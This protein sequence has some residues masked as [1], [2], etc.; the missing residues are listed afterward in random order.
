MKISFPSMI[1]F[2]GLLCLLL[3]L[4]CASSPSSLRATNA[5][6]RGQ[7]YGSPDEALAALKGAFASGDPEQLVLIYGE[8]G[9]NIIITGDPT[10]DKVMLRKMSARLSQRAELLPVQSSEYSEEQWYKVRF[11][12]EGW[13]MRI[14]LINRDNGWYFET[15]YAEDAARDTR[16]AINEVETVATL[17][18]IMQAQ[19]EYILTDHDGDGVRA[20]AS[21]F[22]SSPGKHDGLYWPA[23]PGTQASPLEDVIAEALGDGY[24][25]AQGRNSSYEGYRYRILTA[26]GAKARGGKR[27]YLDNGALTKGYAVL[28]YPV[29]WNSSGLKS[30]LASADG[31]VFK[32]DMGNRTESLGASM[33]EFNPDPTW[34]L[35]EH[36]DN[37]S[38]RIVH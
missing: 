21:Y 31:K 9:R 13:L 33:K 23:A 12:I 11:G 34:A 10:A 5:Q 30:F 25:F 16:Q 1:K 22:I 38:T 8:V 27:S 28:A 35:V 15:R 24:Q 29:T 32:K 6:R 36:P 7:L 3:A 37:Y 20:Y 18:S 2:L 19:R 14:P 4:G 17:W 26:Q